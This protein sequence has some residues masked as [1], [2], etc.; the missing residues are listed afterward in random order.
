MSSPYPTPAYPSPES[1]KRARSFT[2][3]GERQAVYRK[4]HF[5]TTVSP[6]YSTALDSSDTPQLS[7]YSIPV[8][9]S[10]RRR[11]RRSYRRSSRRRSSR[12][13]ARRSGSLVP[14]LSRRQQVAP[15]LSRPRALGPLAFYSFRR[16]SE[17]SYDI[18]A[19]Q[20][21]N[22]PYNCAS[23]TVSWKYLGFRIGDIPMYAEF[24]RLFQYFRLTAVRTTITLGG[25]PTTGTDMRPYLIKVFDPYMHTGNLATSLEDLYQ[26]EGYWEHAC[27]ISNRTFSFIHYPKLH[28]NI[29]DSVNTFAGPPFDGWLRTDAGAAHAQHSGLYVV[30]DNEWNTSTSVSVNIEHDFFF[31]TRG[32]Q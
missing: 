23:G 20:A 29:G 3:A 10:Y 12:R 14:H 7:L 32:L 9:A 22:G 27:D 17:V 5:D 13:V 30:I 1:R 18:G 8:M 25:M 11:S 28:S 21:F 6:H 16:Y 31:D 26:R 4:I 15:V 19:Q 2:P 24:F